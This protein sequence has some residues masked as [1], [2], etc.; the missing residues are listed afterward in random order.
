LAEWIIAKFAE[1]CQMK[2]YV[3]VTT[4][5]LSKGAPP[6]GYIGRPVLDEDAGQ[7]LPFTSPV[8]GSIDC[9]H[10][11]IANALG[12]ALSL[13]EALDCGASLRDLFAG[14]CSHP[15]RQAVWHSSHCFPQP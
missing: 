13:D 12:G 2:L 5:N 11:A 10:N 6:E 7:L 15:V 8:G 1:K 3:P 9:L 14:V 4:A